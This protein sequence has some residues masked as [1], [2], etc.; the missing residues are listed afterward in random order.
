K[1]CY[2]YFL[3]E[4]PT[5]KIADAFINFLKKKKRGKKNLTLAVVLIKPTAK[6]VYFVNLQKKLA[7]K[8]G[9]RLKVCHLSE[10]IAFQKLIVYLK[11]LSNNK[12]IKGVTIPFP[13]P[14]RLMTESLFDYIPPEKEIEGHHRKSPFLPPIGLAILTILKYVFINQKI[15][16]KLFINLKV[17]AQIFKKAFHNKKVVLIGKGSTAGKMIS[18]TLTKA[19]INFLNIH[20]KTPNPEKYY[21]EAD[22]IIS[23][24]GKKVI[25]PEYLRSNAVLI[26][27]GLNFENK[28]ITG[29]YEIDEIKNLASYYTPITNGVDLLNTLYLFK[30]LVDS[31]TK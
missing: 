16:K 14:A 13:L 11:E 18:Q 31:S 2:N 22:V 7:K 17:D 30:N 20:S 24:V 29:D 8:I 15:N 3:M 25:L 4:L 12:Q 5:K 10:R 27:V 6:Q 9:L 19:K 1:F 21:K 28:K 23:A 26:N